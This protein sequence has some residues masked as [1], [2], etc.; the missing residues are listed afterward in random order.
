MD[1]TTWT[2]DRPLDEIPFHDLGQD[3]LPPEE[4]R[5]F[6]R[7][8][9]AL[10]AQQV[11]ELGCTGTYR[12]TE[13]TLTVDERIRFCQKVRQ[14]IAGVGI[15]MTCY[16]PDSLYCLV[17]DCVGGLQPQQKQQFVEVL[18]SITRELHPNEIVG[19]RMVKHAISRYRGETGAHEILSGAG[20]ADDLARAIGDRQG[21]TDGPAELPTV[22]RP[23]GTWTRA[24]DRQATE[25]AWKCPEHSAL[26]WS[27][28]YCVAAE[29][30]AHGS[31]VPDYQIIGTTNACV[32]GKTLC[33]GGEVDRVLVEQVRL[34]A[35]KTE[36]WVRLGAWSLG[37]VRSD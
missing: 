20:D 10:T 11:A 4:V 7:S 25:T 26:T 24:A 19:N 17:H 27:C 2:D 3:M 15:I 23:D 35:E 32:D 18:P 37:L 28:R 14:S 8:C 12:K 30:V 33:P 9:G 13:S 22:G 29:I 1:K 6:L 31:L 36:I 34:R 21:A 16:V 5:E